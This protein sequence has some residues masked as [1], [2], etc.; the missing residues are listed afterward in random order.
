MAKTAYLNVDVRLQ[1]G[2]ERVEHGG[3]PQSRFGLDHIRRGTE[4]EDCPPHTHNG[5]PSLFRKYMAAAALCDELPYISY[6]AN[7]KFI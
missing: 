6:T 7:I 2:G 5:V 3:C 4:N 1:E